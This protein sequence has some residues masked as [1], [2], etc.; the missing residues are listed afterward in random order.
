VVDRGV[1]MADIASQVE[2]GAQHITFGDPDFFNGPTHAMEIVRALHREFPNLTY[3]ATIKVEHLLQHAELLGELCSTGCAFVISAVESLDDAVLARLEKH[4]TRADFVRTVDL[5]RNAGLPLAPTFIAF[6]PWT[7]LASFADLLTTLAEL[8]LVEH[9]APVQLA[10]RL[11]IPTGS[12]LLELEEVRALVGEFDRERLAYPW[13]HPDPRVDELQ[14]RVEAV[15]A[16]VGKHDGARSQV[17]AAV[18]D[19]VSEFI[20]QAAWKSAPLVA[21]AAIPYLTEP[22]Y[23]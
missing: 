11:L 17:F 3:D 20:P 13:Q 2:R 18:R 19:A 12:R 8:D 1:V 10:I 5:M 23:C 21:R 9:V 14:Q 6:T 4:H 22:W 15:V 7:T 16:L